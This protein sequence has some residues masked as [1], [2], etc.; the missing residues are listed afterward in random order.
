LQIETELKMSDLRRDGALGVATLA[1]FA[2]E[3]FNRTKF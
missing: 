3:E 1:M 2:I